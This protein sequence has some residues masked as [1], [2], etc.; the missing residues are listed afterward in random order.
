[1]ED[2]I[3]SKKL[4]IKIFTIIVD[5]SKSMYVSIRKINKRQG[6]CGSLSAILLLLISLLTAPSHQGLNFI[7]PTSVCVEVC[8]G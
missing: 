8:A 2:I 1:M 7:G 3:E 6:T 4:Q 5:N